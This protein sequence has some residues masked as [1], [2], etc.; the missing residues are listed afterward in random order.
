MK[1]NTL[2]LRAGCTPIAIAP[3]ALGHRMRVDLR[4]RTDV[5][6]FYL[7]QY[8]DHEIALLSSL[9]TPGSAVLD[10]GA[11]VGF[12]TIPLARAAAMRGSRVYA[13]EPVQQNVD[14]IR[15][16]LELNRLEQTVNVFPFALS[17]KDATVEI[18]LRQDFVQGGETG[19]ASIVIADG[20]DDPFISQSI[21]TRRLDDI[22]AE[23]PL[24]ISVMKI[25]VEGHES[26]VIA[27]A[28][29]RIARD[30]PTILMEVNHYFQNRK[31][32]D[33]FSSVTAN[34]PEDYVALFP[35]GTVA[36][37]FQRGG[38]FNAFLVP[39]EKRGQV[40]EK[41]PVKG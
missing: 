10:V 21:E 36:E 30:R 1:M 14:R 18:S 17:S 39:L 24:P 23:A 12:F 37:N 29:E 28:R 33:L 7:G 6:A 34:L 22:D 40:Q 27:G 31:Q 3:M 41:L 9:I 11:N 25:D 15:E 8:D 13:F 35:D 26:E 38:I 2:F 20:R 4:T 5:R 16:N 32:I 19:N